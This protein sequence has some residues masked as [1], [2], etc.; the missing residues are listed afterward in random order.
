MGIPEVVGQT[1]VAL[2]A[3]E[4]LVTA[5]N[6]ANS[7]TVTVEL[8]FVL[9]IV[10]LALGTKIL[11]EDCS[12]PRTGLLDRLP[13]AALAADDLLDV[14]PPE[15]VALLL[16]M[17]EPAPVEIVAARSHKLALSLIML[18]LELGLLLL[19]GHGFCCCN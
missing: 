17:T 15:G 19:L 6:P 5:S 7:A 3:V 16:V 9:V 4:I 11:A 13:E 10:Q 1:H 2:V 18:A 8:L 14:V 12:T